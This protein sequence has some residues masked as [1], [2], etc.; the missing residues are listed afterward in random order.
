M[1][2][3]TILVLCQCSID[4]ETPGCSKVFEHLQMRTDCNGNPL[5]HHPL[6][7]WYQ[8]SFFLQ[9]RLFRLIMVRSVDEPGIQSIHLGTMW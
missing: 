1:V 9:I 7:S 4:L 5:P 2:L 8:P 3:Q 6:L